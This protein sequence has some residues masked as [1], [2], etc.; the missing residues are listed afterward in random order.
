[1]VPTRA[2]EQCESTPNIRV[3]LTG[4]ASA[5]PAAYVRPVAAR[6]AGYAGRSAD[7]LR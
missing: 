3:N 6:T 1:M 7:T 5:R 4:R 2:L